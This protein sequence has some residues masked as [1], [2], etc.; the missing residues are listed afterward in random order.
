MDIE[1]K[2]RGRKPKYTPEEALERK[3]EWIK[4]RKAVVREERKTKYLQELYNT[5][6]K[7]KNFDVVKE[8]M[9]KLRIPK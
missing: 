9:M 2:K 5:I 1:P 7:S 8:Q 6:R 3:N 4:N